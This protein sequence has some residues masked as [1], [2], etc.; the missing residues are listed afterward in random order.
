[1]LRLCEGVC[2]V[3]GCD[4]CGFYDVFQHSSAIVRLRLRA[5]DC[6]VLS[7]QV[8]LCDCECAIAILSVSIAQFRLC[9]FECAT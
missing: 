7:M 8:R 1:M 3:L 5:C 9:D 6:A 2:A 4:G